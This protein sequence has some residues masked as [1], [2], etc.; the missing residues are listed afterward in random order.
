MSDNYQ[1]IYSSLEEFKKEL[2]PKHYKRKIEQRRDEEP[3]VFGT[4]LAT[5][6][7][8]DIR[9]KFRESSH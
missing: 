5:D 7:L 6:I 3:G 4:G 8:E 2:L 1:K 9:R